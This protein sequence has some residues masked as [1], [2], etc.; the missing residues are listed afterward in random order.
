MLT[1]SLVVEGEASPNRVEKNPARKKTQGFSLG[2]VMSWNG[3]F[4]AKVLAEPSLLTERRSRL[5][6]IFSKLLLYNTV[7]IK[8][9]ESLEY[10]S[11]S[12]YTLSIY[13]I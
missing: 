9:T 12:L 7:I 11:I 5:S 4:L 8:F 6:K 10:A 13:F 2:L 3:I 1:L